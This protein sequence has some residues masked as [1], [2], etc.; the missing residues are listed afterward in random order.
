MAQVA[1][2]QE[3]IF[4]DNPQETPSEICTVSRPT[5]GVWPVRYL[6]AKVASCGITLSIMGLCVGY[7]FLPSAI[8]DVTSVLLAVGV[9][10]ICCT[11]LH[12]AVKRFLCFLTPKRSMR[13]LAGCLLQSMQE[14]GFLV[15]GEFRLLVRREG[16]EIQCALEGGTPPEKRVFAHSLHE[17]LSPIGSPRYVL[18][19]KAQGKKRRVSAF[20][21]SYA[22]PLAMNQPQNAE[23]LAYRLS[24][25]MGGVEAVDTRYPEGRAIL[26]YCKEL[27]HINKGGT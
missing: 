6:L 24:R 15:T 11:V 13:T 10:G 25:A 18:L 2:R 27:S 19:R 5:R 1:N 8:N 9:T 22:C 12:G 14:A 4:M 20:V 3:G 26:Q 17:M 16:R 21:Q 23:L 7:L